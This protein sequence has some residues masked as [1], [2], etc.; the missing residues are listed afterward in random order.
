[1]NSDRNRFGERD[2]F[3]VTL[4]CPFQPLLTTHLPS[5][6]STLPPFMMGKEIDQ[7]LG[8]SGTVK[9]N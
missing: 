3:P 5:V 6:A 7:A 9:S 4:L 1:M 2:L 8:L